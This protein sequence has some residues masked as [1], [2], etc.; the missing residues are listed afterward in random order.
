MRKELKY[1]PLD[2]QGLEISNAVVNTFPTKTDAQN[3]FTL[4]SFG[5]EQ[6]GMQVIFL[7]T[8]KTA[9]WDGTQFIEGSYDI[10]IVENFST[11]PDPTTVVNKFYWVLNAQGTSWLAGFIGG[12]YYNKGLYYSDGTSWTF[13]EV[14]FQATQIEVDAGTDD[15]K[16]V[17]PLTLKNAL[18][19]LTSDFINDGEDGIHKYVT[20]LDLPSNLILY[21]TTDSSDIVGYIKMVT[22][23]HDPSYN[24]TAV[25]VST[26]EI[27]GI[28]QLISSLASSTNII[29]GN[30]GVFN[31]TTVGNITK[32]SGS[33]EAEFFFRVYKRELSG[34]ETL[35]A[36]SSNTIPVVN[37]GYSEFSATAV[38][39]DGIFLLSD[40]I[41]IK[42]YANRIG[43]GSNPT[44]QFQFGGMT[45]VRTLVPITLQ[46][47]PNNGLSATITDYIDATLPLAGTEQVLVEQGGTFKKVYI[48]DFLFT[49]EY[50][51]A[52]WSV[53]PS[54]NTAIAGG[55]VYDYTLNGTT[56]Y[57]F[58][59][60]TYD[61]TQDAFYESFDGTTLT[62]LITKRG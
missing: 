59:P 7:D 62:T 31:I 29:E 35:I 21:P 1:N 32:V 60:T 44:Y 56:R 43:G 34:T 45:P 14:P 6:K 57:R 2:L 8:L 9:K 28:T 23:I 25:D 26:G 4:K 33:G 16:F 55:D 54:L 48:S 39:N 36:Q 10:E 5:V 40:R 19:T 50:L 61:P 13:S 17:T 20:L 27:T 47:V 18:P 49:W 53:E 41:V 37:T 3:Y 11:L 22:D 46:T 42:Y 12:N 52:N 24:T 51:V 30:P 38:W 15:T 58:V